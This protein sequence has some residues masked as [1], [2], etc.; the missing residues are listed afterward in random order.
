M[1]K[2]LDRIG[3]A[4]FL[5]GVVAALGFGAQT[6]VAASQ[7]LDC[8]CVPGPGADAFCEKCCEAD[9]SICPPVGT[10]PRECLCA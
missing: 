1:S 7:T 10:E 6:A 4:A 5:L 8:Q 9:E 2:V 3:R